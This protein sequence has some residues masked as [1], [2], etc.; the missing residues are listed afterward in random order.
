MLEDLRIATPCS[1]DWDDM[2]GDDR[3]R[4]CRQCD[5]LVYNVIAMTRVEAESLIGEQEGEVCVRLYRRKDGTVLTSDCPVAVERERFHRRMWASISSVAASVGLLIGLW[6]GRARADLSPSEGSKASS[7]PAAPCAGP[8]KLPPKPPKA[9]PKIK[10]QPV[11]KQAEKPR[12]KR[13][14]PGAELMIGQGT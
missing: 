6:S 7:K 13:I 8:A 3:A 12:D 4:L 11:K 14:P 9:E 2:V 5:K 10:P 1:A